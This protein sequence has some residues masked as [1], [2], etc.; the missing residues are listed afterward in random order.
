M[1]A[2]R[3]TQTMKPMTAAK[4]LGIYLPATPESFREAGEITRSELARLMTSPPEWLVRLREAG[5]HPRE[6][7]ASRLRVSIAGLARAGVTEALTTEQIE[8]LRQE[9]PVWLVQ[10]RETFARVQADEE[11]A[12]H[13]RKA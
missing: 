7:V 10:E 9:P 4:K 2:G 1:T 3:T 8:D 11:Q 5:P 6:V 12:A 13:R